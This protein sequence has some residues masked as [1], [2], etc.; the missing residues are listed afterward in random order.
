MGLSLALCHPEDAIMDS[1]DD[2]LTLI[3]NSLA[4]AEYYNVKESWLVCG[5]NRKGKLVD[6]LNRLCALHANDYGQRVDLAIEWLRGE[7]VLC[8]RYTSKLLA[9]SDYGRLPC[10]SVAHIVV[11]TGKI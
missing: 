11:A 1:N 8:P 6:G 5:S 9:E 3:Q 4:I 2:F 10:G 7:G